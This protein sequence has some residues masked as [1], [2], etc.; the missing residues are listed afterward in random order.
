MYS[1]ELNTWKAWIL[2]AAMAAEVLAIVCIA[3]AVAIIL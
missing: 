1:G 2:V 3:A